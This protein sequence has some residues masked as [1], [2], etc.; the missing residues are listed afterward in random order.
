MGLIPSH[1]FSVQ[2]LK[3]Q[4]NKFEFWH[5]TIEGINTEE[6]YSMMQKKP[7]AIQMSF[8]ALSE[9]SFS[10]NSDNVNLI[11]PLNSPS[12]LEKQDAHDIDADNSLSGI[13]VSDNGVKEKA[14][15]KGA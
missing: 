1:Q 6:T 15:S 8:D 14:K 3:L 12:K 4:L 10:G 7:D 5:T 13:I 2:T 11:A 9:F